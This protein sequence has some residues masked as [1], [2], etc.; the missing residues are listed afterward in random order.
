MGFLSRGTG[1]GARAMGFAARAM[2]FV[3][4]AM[5]FAARAMGFLARAMGSSARAAGST[6]RAVGLAARAVGLAARAA[7]FAGQAGGDLKRGAILRLG[8]RVRVVRRGSY[9]RGEGVDA[10]VAH[11]A[12]VRTK[13]DLLVKVGSCV[14]DLLGG[15]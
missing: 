8:M 12:G 14:F 2:A 6:A 4:R 3:A 1:C 7:G 15:L 13:L 11:F 9:G 5:G 10:S